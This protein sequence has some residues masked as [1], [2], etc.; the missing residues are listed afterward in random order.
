MA[1]HNNN[2]DSLQLYGFA[3]Y[4]HSPMC[5][6]IWSA[7]T[8]FFSFFLKVH[9]GEKNEEARGQGILWK[10]HNTGFRSPGSVFFLLTSKILNL[11]YVMSL[12]GNL[13]KLLDPF[14]EKMFLIVF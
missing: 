6:L 13:R 9:N 2:S 12:F 7:W 10:L 14:S 4:R 1:K 11:F 3:I 8:F 5:Y